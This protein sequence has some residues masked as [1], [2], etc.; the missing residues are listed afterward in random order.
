MP[1]SNQVLEAVLPVGVISWKI[2]GKV[3]KMV[4]MSSKGLTVVI[5]NVELVAVAVMSVDLLQLGLVQ[6]LVPGL[7]QVVT[8][9]VHVVLG[10][11]ALYSG[12]WGMGIITP[13]SCSSGVRSWTSEQLQTSS[14]TLLNTVL[15]IIS[16]FKYYYPQR[17]QRAGGISKGLVISWLWLSLTTLVIARDK[18]WGKITKFYDNFEPPYLW[19]ENSF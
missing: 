4:I 6:G 5:Q 9:L 1:G 13:A 7:V 11:E 17:A 8:H 15:V 12:Y 3:V 14:A 2:S 18:M 16:N 10:Q 19:T